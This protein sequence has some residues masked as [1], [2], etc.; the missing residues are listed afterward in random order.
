MFLNFFFKQ[1]FSIN[2]KGFCSID[3]VYMSLEIDIHRYRDKDISLL[4]L[5]KNKKQKTKQRED[6][7]TYFNIFLL[8]ITFFSFVFVCFFFQIGSAAK[9]FWSQFM[10]FSLK[11]MNFVCWNAPNAHKYILSSITDLF[12]LAHFLGAQTGNRSPKCSCYGPA[13]VF[14]FPCQIFI[15]LSFDVCSLLL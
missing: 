9:C 14:I 11:E 1:Y 10:G 13:C 6:L 3:V 8:T 5:D 15:C 2:W 7:F 12:I 4:S